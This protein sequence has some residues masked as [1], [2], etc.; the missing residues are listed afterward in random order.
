VNRI[1]VAGVPRS[2]STWVAHV[3]AQTPD[4]TLLN[5][6]DNHLA[7]PFALRA[8]RRLPGGFHPALMPEQPAGDYEL[9]WRRALSFPP[10][11]DE[12]SLDRPTALLRH[13]ISL[14]LLQSAS[15]AEKWAAFSSGGRLSRRLWAAE[16]LAIPEAPERSARNLIVKSVY[17]ALSLEW[18]AHRFPV[19]IL[20]VL[21][22]PL[23]VL[24]SWSQIGWLGR[25]GDDMLDTLQEPVQIELGDKWGVPPPPSGSSI[26]VRAA[27]LVGALTCELIEVAR[28]N[29]G[30]LT[31]T[32]EE[33]CERPHE[34]FPALADGL[35]LR[36]GT[37][38][39]RLV[40][41]MDRPGSGY[42]LQRVARDLPEAWRTRLTQ[43][44]VAE[45]LSVLSRFPLDERLVSRAP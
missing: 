17:A 11:E 40:D 35:G 29:P 13:K 2:G 31:V 22:A 36:W 26:I 28:R 25:T 30:W 38:M 14:Q 3:L 24:S 12:P 37:E 44:Y 27:W 6:P 8:K 41:D 19:R 9:L 4:A 21:R 39:T 5:E 34:R 15:Q 7:F 16:R 43:Q 20:V 33:L 32:H 1:L 42:E 18:L 23:N 45:A 10:R